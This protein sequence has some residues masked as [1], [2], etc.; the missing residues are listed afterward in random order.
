MPPDVISKW[1][2][3]GSWTLVRDFTTASMQSS[4][5]GG[6]R[7]RCRV[8]VRAGAPDPNWGAD[9]SRGYACGGS[10]KR[11][12]PPLSPSVRPE[13]PP[14]GGFLLLEGVGDGLGD[15]GRDLDLP[16]G[17]VVEDLAARRPGRAWTKS[18]ALHGMR[19]LREVGV[20]PEG[21]GRRAVVVGG[22]AYL[23]FSR[24]PGGFEG[25]RLAVV[26]EGA[27]HCPWFLKPN[28]FPAATLAAGNLIDP[29]VISP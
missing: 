1:R 5:V 10:E 24:Q 27:M 17:L 15:R 6:S 28:C 19:L 3:S 23:G 8:R 9:W 16:L 21:I 2:I 26:D 29:G 14:S 11:I 12:G 4:T 20:P 7:L 25:A 22:G 18:G 13:S